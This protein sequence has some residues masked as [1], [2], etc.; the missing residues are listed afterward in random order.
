[1][2]VLLDAFVPINRTLPVLLDAIFG[3]PPRFG[4]PQLAVSST[5]SMKT[6]FPAAKPQFRISLVPTR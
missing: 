3:G 4:V 6:A 2:R 1:M 5:A